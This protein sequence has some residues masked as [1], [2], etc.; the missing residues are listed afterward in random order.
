M[1]PSLH[2]VFS[3]IF[4]FFLHFISELNIINLSIIFF[5]SILIDLDHY[6]LFIRRKKRLNIKEFL[7]ENW[8]IMYKWEALSKNEKSQTKMEPFLLHGVEALIILGV[9]ALFYEI[10]F[11]IFIGFAFHL[12]LDQIEIII[13]IKHYHPFYKFSQIWLWQR[14]KN[15]KSLR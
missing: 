7:N 6:F 8:R 3:F 13:K 12:I 4:V 10:F 15:K 14:N 1:K 2:L 9:L 11:L 5:A